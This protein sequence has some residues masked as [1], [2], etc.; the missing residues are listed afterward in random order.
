MP[1]TTRLALA[2]LGQLNEAHDAV[3][4]AIESAGGRADGQQWYVHELL[5]IKS[6]ILLRRDEARAMPLVEDCFN[7]VAQMAI[8]Q[9]AL[10]WE[11]RFAL[12]R[13][14]SRAA[15]GRRKEAIQL[16]ASVYDRFTEGFE[17]PD[18]RAA[19]AYLDEL[20]P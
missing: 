4:R 12:G 19:K 7:K 6:E 1:S 3:T 13:A 15:Q 8:E 9:G 14:R 2:G 17:T 18:L 10:F 20:S 11:L 5:R 16:L